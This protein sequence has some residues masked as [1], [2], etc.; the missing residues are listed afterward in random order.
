MGFR[1]IIK[2]RRVSAP[3]AAA[4]LPITLKIEYPD[5]TKL[6]K[7]RWSW[8]K[9]GGALLLGATLSLAGSIG[10]QWYSATE[11][12]SA[13]IRET[14]S[15][16]YSEMLSALTS[17]SNTLTEVMAR[18]YVDQDYTLDEM[19]ASG[20]RLQEGIDRITA[21][22]A[23]IL[24]IGSAEVQTSSADLLQAQLEIS[25]SAQ[26]A[27]LN[28]T[29]ATRKISVFD[30]DYFSTYQEALGC[31]FRTSIGPFLIAARE[32]L[33]SGEVQGTYVDCEPLSDY[34]D[35]FEVEGAAT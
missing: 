22:Y 30:E 9:T 32:E 1:N 21:S 27:L 4:P 31:N 23:Q 25:S 24:V 20:D 10:T 16:A 19:T 17:Q 12:R 13:S 8:L 33:G 15:V 28:T 34:E 35:D 26:S 29:L 2:P 18:A 3:P 5:A 14:R 11:E 6:P 7:D